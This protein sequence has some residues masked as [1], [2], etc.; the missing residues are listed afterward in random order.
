[1]LDGRGPADVKVRNGPHSAISLCGQKQSI[2]ARR[3][4]LT[5]SGPSGFLSWYARALRAEDSGLRTDG[6]T[7]TRRPDD[8]RS[9]QF[10][11]SPSDL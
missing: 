2:G 5:G 8:P 1:M 6:S 11:L 7:E 3:V 10:D 4:G 9:W